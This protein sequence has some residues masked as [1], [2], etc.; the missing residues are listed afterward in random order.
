MDKWAEKETAA[1]GKQPTNIRPQQQTEKHV[2]FCQNVPMDSSEHCLFLENGST[3]YWT[4]KW[5]Q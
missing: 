5:I 2:I 3:V 1:D 4:A